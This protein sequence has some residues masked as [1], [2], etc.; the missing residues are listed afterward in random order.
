[1]SLPRSIRVPS[2]PE[3]APFD[4]EQRAW[5]NGFLA[6]LFYDQTEAGLSASSSPPAQEL[7]APPAPP[8]PGMFGSATGTAGGP[9]ARVPQEAA[10]HGFIPPPLSPQDPPQAR[11]SAQE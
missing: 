5:I 3:S 7:S 2:L 6:G 1:M 10:A 4:S 9:A 11:T 8:L